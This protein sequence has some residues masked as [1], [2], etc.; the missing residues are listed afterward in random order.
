MSDAD[1]LLVDHIRVPIHLASRD[2]AELLGLVRERAPDPS[3]FSEHPPVFFDAQVSSKEIDSYSTMMMR[4]TLKNYAADAGAPPSGVA[5]QDS[6]KYDG[7]ARTLGRSVEGHFVQGRGDNPDRTTV[8]FFT[9]P[10]LS[11]QMEEFVQRARSGLAADVSVGFIGGR[12]VCSICGGEM[13]G[14]WYG[15]GGE[16]ACWHY[17]GVE[18]P[19]LDGNG[20]KT[21]ET[22]VAIGQ[23]EDAHLSEVS[24]VFDGATPN[25]GIIGMKARAASAAGQLPDEVRRALESRWQIDITDGRR[26]FVP[27][28]DTAG[29][30]ARPVRA[31]DTTVVPTPQE[32]ER[33]ADSIYTQEDLDRAL[34]TARAEATAPVLAAIRATGIELPTDADA[35]AGV[36]ALAGKLGD[37]EPRAKDGDT[38]RDD[39]IEE[40]LGHGV[41]VYGNAFDKDAERADLRALPIASIKRQIGKLKPLGDDIFKGGRSTEDGDGV[42]LREGA[43]PVELS[44]RR[45]HRRVP[46]AYG[47]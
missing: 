17:P 39:L 30:A 28:P 38:Y 44:G 29:T 13:F 47:G 35:V 20:K 25:A 42:K 19:V 23:I 32:G 41:R 18:Y 45:R 7:M 37:L 14:W 12:T 11:P 43:T 34:A 1:S 33:M 9:Q 3:V 15:R 46:E 10:S 5:F 4:S 40:C 22:V 27:A 36:R 21:K 16:D 24:T 2:Q 26:L 31:E 6:H 8:T